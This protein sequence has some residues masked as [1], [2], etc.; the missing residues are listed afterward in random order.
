MIAVL[1]RRRPVTDASGPTEYLRLTT[2]IAVTIMTFSQAQKFSQHSPA[3]AEFAQAE[4]ICTSRRSTMPVTPA[5]G[6]PTEWNMP[7]RCCVAGNLCGP[8]GD[9]SVGV[10]PSKVEASRV[11]GG[12]A[13]ARSRKAAA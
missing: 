5:Q 4:R 8:G 13:E 3:A 11:T 6:R 1:T 2:R 9:L 7:Y 10:T 12:A